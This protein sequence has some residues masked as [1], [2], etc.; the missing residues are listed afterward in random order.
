[1]SVFD[2]LEG[3]RVCVRGGSGGVSRTTTS[4][5]IAPA[6]RPSRPRSRFLGPRARLLTA[7]VAATTIRVVVAAIALAGVEDAADEVAVEA[8]GSRHGWF[9]AGALLA[10]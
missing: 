8:D 7:A 4:A 10:S 5:A 2:P 6:W 3:K 9:A 1:M